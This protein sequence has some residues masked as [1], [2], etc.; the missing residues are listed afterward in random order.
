MQDEIKCPKCDEGTL[1]VVG[2]AGDKRWINLVCDTCGERSSFQEVNQQI[3]E[4]NTEPEDKA[5]KPPLG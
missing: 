4:K 5:D 3:R 1:E 2:R